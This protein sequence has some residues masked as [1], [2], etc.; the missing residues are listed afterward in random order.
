MQ[1]GCTN[2]LSV[3]DYELCDHCSYN[4]YNSNSSNNNHCNYSYSYNYNG[5]T[6]TATT[7]TTPSRPQH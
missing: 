1:T 7:A 6:T 5:K 3:C 4:C 2:L